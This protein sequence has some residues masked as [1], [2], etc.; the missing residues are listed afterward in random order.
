M[1]RSGP[2]LIGFVG[3]NC[4]AS[5]LRTYQRER[6]IE[7]MHFPRALERNIELPYRFVSFWNAKDKWRSQIS[8]FH[9]FGRWDDHPLQGVICLDFSTFWGLGRLI[10]DQ[11]AV[12]LGMPSLQLRP[13]TK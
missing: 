13:F 10:K 7:S 12:P 1:V 9:S 8:S 6:S 3:R 11:L 5:K 2:A 4:L